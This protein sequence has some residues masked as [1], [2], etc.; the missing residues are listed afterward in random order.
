MS[1]QITRN[2]IDK[3]DECQ[4]N[5]ATLFCKECNNNLCQHCWDI[6][7]NN[8]QTSHNIH[9]SHS[10]PSQLVIPIKDISSIFH[11]N[12]IIKYD[13]KFRNGFHDPEDPPKIVSHITLLSTGHTTILCDK[14]LE[15]EKFMKF[16]LE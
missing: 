10:P 13:S 14:K 4:N 15:N 2:N 9:K 5:I 12:Q 3:C 1:L 8:N 7:H 11:F 6:I 16:H